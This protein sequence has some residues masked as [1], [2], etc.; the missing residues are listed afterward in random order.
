[1]RLIIT[2]FSLLFIFNSTAGFAQIKNNFA[3]ET[4]AKMLNLM[5]EI[6]TID[7]SVK[8]AARSQHHSYY[9]YNFVR[10]PWSISSYG[11]V[12]TTITGDLAVLGLATFIFYLMEQNS[13]SS[14]GEPEF[15]VWPSLSVVLASG[16][17]SLR[18]QFPSINTS[19]LDAEEEQIIEHAR[20]NFNEYARN[21]AHNYTIAFELTAV[22]K[23][24]VEKRLFKYFM[25]NYYQLATKRS[26]NIPDF[27]IIKY[28]KSEDIAVDRIKI[29]EAF[30]ANQKAYENQI[31]NSARTATH[32]AEILEQKLKN[33]KSKK[34]QIQELVD[35]IETREAH[36]TDPQLDKKLQELKREI[37]E[38]QEN[39]ALDSLM[40]GEN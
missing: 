24:K 17:E 14:K 31:K 5:I 15:S 40:N 7:K 30:Q 33:L 27:N 29:Y 13:G 21:Y 35:I 37:L 32:D 22:E 28:L 11:D 4:N 23:N 6:A 1:M 8:S 18:N 3:N 34:E 39:Y 2:F 12:S 16:A 20:A 19:I 36:N 25:D 10:P 26:T 38:L 9:Q